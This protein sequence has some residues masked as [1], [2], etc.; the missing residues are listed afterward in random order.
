MKTS[1]VALLIY[2]KIW[3]SENHANLAARNKHKNKNNFVQLG[4]A[5]LGVLLSVA[6][7]TFMLMSATSE[8]LVQDR[9]SGNK[10]AEISV[11]NWISL[12]LVL[13]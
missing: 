3:Q 9:L 4:E 5:V 7:D 11:I 6:R 2:H 1:S 13:V 10:V 8:P 12:Y